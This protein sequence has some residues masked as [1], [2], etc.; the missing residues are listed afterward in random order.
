MNSVLAF[1]LPAGRWVRHITV[2]TTRPETMLGDTVVA[3]HPDD[4]RYA[5]L[6]GKNV[7]LPIVGRK[8]PLLRIATPIL[9]KVQVQLKLPQRM[10]LM[11][12]RLDA[13]AP[14]SVNILDKTVRIE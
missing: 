4:E 9:S 14:E 1:Q 10:I 13:D 8:F 3:V 11:T 6:V 2:A 12:L 7:I 5:D